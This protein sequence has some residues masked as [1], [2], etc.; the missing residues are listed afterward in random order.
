M[1][2]FEAIIDFSHNRMNL[3]HEEGFEKH[4][5]HRHLLHSKIGGIVSRTRDT[6]VDITLY[7][8]VSSSSITKRTP[9]LGSI[10]V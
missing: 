5:R 8:L 2:Y 9:T 3:I 6:N 4:L 7:P 10:S 1:Q